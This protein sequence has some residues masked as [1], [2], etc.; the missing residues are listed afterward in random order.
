MQFAMGFFEDLSTVVD[1]N[2]TNDVSMKPFTARTFFTQEMIP[3]MVNCIKG[4]KVWHELAKPFSQDKIALPNLFLILSAE[5]IKKVCIMLEFL[6]EGIP[7][8]A[9]HDVN[10]EV[11]ENDQS[12]SLWKQRAHSLQVLDSG[13]SAAQGSGTQEWSREHRLNNFLPMKP[14]VAGANQS[15]SKPQP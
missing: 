10:S 14:S 12:R 5:L 7:A 1:G 11:V 13:I 15:W 3:I 9:Q 6:M 8:V 2:S 4:K